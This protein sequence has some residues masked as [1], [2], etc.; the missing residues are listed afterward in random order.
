[1]KHLKLIGL[2]VLTLSASLVWGA[3]C[4]DTIRGDGNVLVGEGRQRAQFHVSGAEQNEVISGKL[5][6][7]DRESGIRLRSRNLTAYETVDAETR[8]LT[9]DLGS[10]GTNAPATAIVTLRDLGR[11][12]RNDFFE[13]AS[14]DYL[15]S[16]NLRG[17]QIRLQRRGNC[18]DAAAA[19]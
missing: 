14:G 12:G 8:R 9:F 15:A 4:R 5:D 6:F 10:D 17:G 7:R 11:K 18:D 19:E 2:S 3:D 16:G 13:I 1:M